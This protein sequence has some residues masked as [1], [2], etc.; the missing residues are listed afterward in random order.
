MTD[1]ILTIRWRNDE[2]SPVKTLASVLESGEVRISTDITLSECKFVIKM[3][4][5]DYALRRRIPKS[6]MQIND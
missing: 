4:L 6:E 5:D 1:T 2:S 3:L